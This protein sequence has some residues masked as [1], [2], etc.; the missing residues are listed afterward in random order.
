MSE[1][2]VGIKDEKCGHCY[3]FNEYIVCDMNSMSILF[4]WIVSFTM[5][6]MLSEVSVLLWI[7]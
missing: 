1:R 6:R 4:A 7:S 5:L 3:E 2:H